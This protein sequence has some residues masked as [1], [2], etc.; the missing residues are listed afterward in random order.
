MRHANPSR[1]S[2]ITIA[3]QHLQRPIDWISKYPSSLRI[4]SI[5][6]NE[7]LPVR[8]THRSSPLRH[9]LNTPPNKPKCKRP[10]C[11][12]ANTWTCYKRNCVY[13]ITC[14]KCEDNSTSAAQDALAWP[15]KK[16]CREIKLF[17]TLTRARLS[18]EPQLLSYLRWDQG[19]RV[20]FHWL[21][22]P[23]SLLHPLTL[24][25]N[26]FTHGM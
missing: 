3:M 22:P 16:T 21:A 5:F 6:K 24:T 15:H 25:N 17:S 10:Q 4:A 13:P 2:T 12:I 9:A 26:Q 20:G 23:C 14:T 7:G 19:S 18:L 11:P 1:R 8:I